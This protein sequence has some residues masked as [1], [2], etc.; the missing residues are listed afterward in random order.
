MTA[1]PVRSEPPPTVRTPEPAAEPEPPYE[2]PLRDAPVSVFADALRLFS[3]RW[4]LATKGTRAEGIAKEELSRAEGLIR[5][6]MTVQCPRCQGAKTG[7]KSCAETGA[8][9]AMD[10]RIVTRSMEAG[11]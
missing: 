1:T 11:R 2:C 4:L 9:T 5:G 3:R 7:C 8:V 6:A 10:A